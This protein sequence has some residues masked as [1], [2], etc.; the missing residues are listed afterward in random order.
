M[1][2]NTKKPLADS[3]NTRRM[4]FPFISLPFLMVLVEGGQKELMTGGEE[5][6]FA[7]VCVGGGSAGGLGA[8]REKEMF[9]TFAHFVNPSGGIVMR[10]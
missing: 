8:G 1:T 9:C 5:Q 4:Q 7:C 3:F 6:F 2:S 10:L